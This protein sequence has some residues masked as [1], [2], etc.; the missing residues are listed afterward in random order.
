VNLTAIE[1]VLGKA[2]SVEK[3]MLFNSARK[4]LLCRSPWVYEEL[5]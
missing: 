2:A 3:A 5:A 1:Q 4:K